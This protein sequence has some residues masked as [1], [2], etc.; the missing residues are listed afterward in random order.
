MTGGCNENNQPCVLYQMKECWLEAYLPLQP[1]SDVIT[2]LKKVYENCSYQRKNISRLTMEDKMRLIDTWA[3]TTVNLAM[4][5]NKAVINS[6]R[7][8]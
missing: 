3:I 7:V 5:D 8:L 2:K 4:K 6:D 1:D